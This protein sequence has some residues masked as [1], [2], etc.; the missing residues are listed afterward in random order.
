MHNQVRLELLYELQQ[1]FAVS[2]IQWGM[3][4]GWDLA[5]EAFQNPGSVA[6]RSEKNRSVIVVDPGDAETVSREK[7]RN[8]GANQPA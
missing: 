1:G 8:L 4:I 2:D 6:F 7:Q 3:S 5:F